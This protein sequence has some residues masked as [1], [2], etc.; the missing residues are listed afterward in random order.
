MQERRPLLRPSFPL[1]TRDNLTKPRIKQN[2]NS[3]KINS[4]TTIVTF[5]F[6]PIIP[7]LIVNLNNT[8]WETLLHT[9]AHYT[10]RATHFVLQKTLL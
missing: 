9:A 6:F 7:I 3:N 8:F 10:I 1:F 4:L 2:I 5:G